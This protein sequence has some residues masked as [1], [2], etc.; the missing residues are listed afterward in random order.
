MEERDERDQ[1]L[2]EARR[3]KRDKDIPDSRTRWLLVVGDWEW[4]HA[5]CDA[6]ANSGGLCAFKQI[7]E[8][9][10]H[11]C[12]A[13]RFPH[14]HPRVLDIR[15]DFAEETG[16]AM[17]EFAIDAVIGTKMKVNVEGCV[18]AGSGAAVAIGVQVYPLGVSEP[19]IERRA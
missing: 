9:A 4:M 16:E 11:M 10:L 3:A 5:G 8:L 7:R 12:H 18:A 6:R 17:L 13:R 1:L 14:R 15:C 19:Q 2:I